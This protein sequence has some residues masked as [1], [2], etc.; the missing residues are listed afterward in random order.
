MSLVP[1]AE[2]ELKNHP[3]DKKLCNVTQK[4]LGANPKLEAQQIAFL[5]WVVNIRRSP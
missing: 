5:M 1:K 3:N 4:P 2:Q